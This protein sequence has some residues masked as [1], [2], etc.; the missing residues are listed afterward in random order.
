MRPGHFCPGNHLFL[1]V[2]ARLLRRFNEA[3]AFLPRKLAPQHV[4]HRRVEEASMRPGHFCPG[5]HGLVRRG[6]GVDR[7]SMRP[8]HFCPGNSRPRA[9]PPPQNVRF[10]EA[11]A[12]LP[13]KP[14]R[15]FHGQPIPVRASMRPGHFC[16]GNGQTYQ[17]T[18]VDESTLQ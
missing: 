1:V 3:G 17:A 15:N 6:G 9:H 13:R 11:G 12:F 5:N 16:P 14:R 10:N 4:P 2:V 8:G 18:A 7:A